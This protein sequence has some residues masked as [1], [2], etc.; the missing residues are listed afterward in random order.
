MFLTAPARVT[1]LLAPFVVLAAY[2]AMAY[3]AANYSGHELWRARGA[4]V[5]AYMLAN[6]QKALQLNAQVGLW[7]GGWCMCCSWLF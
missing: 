1:V 2:G 4:R 6:R 3:C 5:H 7:V